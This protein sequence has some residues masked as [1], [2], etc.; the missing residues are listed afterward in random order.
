MD[1]AATLRRHRRPLLPGLLRHRLVLPL[2]G[3]DRRARTPAPV[4]RCPSSVYRQNPTRLPLRPNAGSAPNARRRAI[5]QRLF[6]V[7]SCH[8]P[9][10]RHCHTGRRRSAPLRCQTTPGH[11]P[12]RTPNLRLATHRPH[13]LHRLHHRHHRRRHVLHPAALG[14]RRL[15]TPGTVPRPISRTIERRLTR[16]HRRDPAE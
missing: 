12:H 2:R 8:L 1:P 11:C 3:L 16:C 9:H 13:R 15:P 7:L 5:R 4:P 10:V 6:P 14:P